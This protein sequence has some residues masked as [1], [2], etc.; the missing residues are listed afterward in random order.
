MIVPP[1]QWIG[2]ADSVR[3][4]PAKEPE[5]WEVRADLQVPC[6]TITTRRGLEIAHLHTRESALADAKVLAAAP[7]MRELLATYPPPHYR[8]SGE[9]YQAVQALLKRLE[10]P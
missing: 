1:D 4:P 10:T 7:E 8:D 5:R 9:E 2:R 3:V 6:C